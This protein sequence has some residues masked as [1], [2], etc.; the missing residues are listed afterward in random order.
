MFEDGEEGEA[1]KDQDN[2]GDLL[3]KFVDYISV[4]QDKSSDSQAEESCDA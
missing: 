4:S 1:G 3:T 2:E